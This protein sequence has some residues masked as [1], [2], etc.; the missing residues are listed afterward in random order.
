MLGLAYRVDCVIPAS[1]QNEPERL[2]SIFV[3]PFTAVVLG[4]RSLSWEAGIPGSFVDFIALLHYQLLL[5]P[6]GT[7]IVG[8]LGLLS[9][10]SLL[11]GL[12]LW[13]P[14]I[15]RW[16]RAASIKRHARSQR[17]NR[18]LLN[19]IGFLSLMVIGAVL[20]SGVSMNLNNPF[21]ALTRF[22]S[23]ATRAPFEQLHSS[24]AAGRAPIGVNQALT[25][26]AQY[27][28][29]GQLNWL[30]LPDGQSS[31]YTISRRDVPGLSYFWSER[32]VTLDQYSGAVLDVR[33]PETRHT[34]GETFL[35]WQ[36]QLH[37]G[38]AF[39]WAGRL[40][41]FLGGIACAVIYITGVLRWMQKRSS[42]QAA[43]DRRARRWNEPN[44]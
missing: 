3:D 13:W 39:G 38:Q 12:I 40:L 14:I 18:N 37:S 4:E 20:L 26:A 31:V 32:T 34:A 35:D 42:R 11:T 1:N 24:P 21:V 23:P 19:T 33:S 22:F 25:I 15:G 7:T 16:Q 43:Q 6:I 8:I 2:T 27:Y 41:V 29:A 10:F 17:L 9:L 36:W 28:P 5:G 30:G 44:A